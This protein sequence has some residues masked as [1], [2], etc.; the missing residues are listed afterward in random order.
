MKTSRTLKI[1]LEYDG[2][3]FS[4]WQ[5][6]PDKWT[7]QKAVEE[8]LERIL[9]HQVRLTAAGRTDAGVHAAGQV[10]NFTTT[11]GIETDRLAK[12]I[13]GLLPKDITVIDIKDVNP[14]FNARYNAQSRT[15]R[16]TLSDKRLS[17]GREYAWH[18]KLKLSRELLEHSTRPLNGPCNL[19]GFSKG[20]DDDDFS[21]IIFNNSWTFKD[22]FMIF[23]ICAVRFFH[24]AVR[25]IVGSAV[26]VARGKEP[27]DLIQR[28]LDTRDRSLAGT[29]APAKG[30]CLVK[31]DYGKETR[32]IN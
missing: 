11:S 5:I 31:V 7:V 32:D 23:E 2:T 10:V 26:E 20:S 21:S 14:G 12:G 28:I 22:N 3:R 17:I 13:N 6:Q 16:Y 27:P 4:G 29:T 24:R 15:Y 9:N 1:V 8:A 25:S 18:V 30:L 19:R